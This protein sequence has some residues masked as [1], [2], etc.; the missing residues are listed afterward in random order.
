MTQGEKFRLYEDV[1]TRRGYEHQEGKLLEE[2]GELITAISRFPMRA[3][4]HDV[5]TELA[6]VSIMVEQ[7]AYHHGYEAFCQERE[8]KLNRLK[9]RI[10]NGTIYND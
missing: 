8:Y 10:E 2:C 3:E 9:E 1:L 4:R 7:M 5:I 6:D